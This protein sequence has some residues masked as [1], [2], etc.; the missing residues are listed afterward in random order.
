MNGY[1]NCVQRRTG[2]SART[3]QERKLLLERAARI[4]EL[5]LDYVPN[6]AFD[7]WRGDKEAE[8]EV[9]GPMP[10][11]RGSADVD[12]RTVDRRTADWRTAEL[13]DSGAA[14]REPAGR[15]PAGREPAGRVPAGRVPAGRVPAGRVPAGRVPAPS[16]LAPYVASL[17]EV[18]LLTRE[19]EVHLFRKLNY[20]KF[21]IDRLRGRLKPSRPQRKLLARIEELCGETVAT[22]NQI[23]SANL[24]LVVSIAKRY[25]GPGQNF[26]E[27]V[28]DGNL[29]LMRAVER[30]D[31]SLGNRFSTYATWAII[32]NFSRS[33][34][35]SV[36][37]RNRFRS[38]PSGLLT[39]SAEAPTNRHELEAAQSRRESA[40]DGILRRLNDRER[41]IIICRYGLRRGDQP[42]TLQQ[43]GDVMGVSKERIRQIEARAM[44][45]LRQAVPPELLPRSMRN[46]V[47]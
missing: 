5:P 15:E 40:L 41:E 10:A 12:R 4:L 45:K 18:P 2:F 9:L 43:V 22:R 42:Q 13:A 27:L 47:T 30:F 8:S 46:A 39:A 14:G 36:C 20:L 6:Q 38:D 26:F 1:V 3:R 21:K 19:Q 11:H 37:Y 16:G 17:Y 34:Q 31:Y 35:E 29:S 23:I 24:R 44:E 28:S 25:V 32:N 7:A 33:I